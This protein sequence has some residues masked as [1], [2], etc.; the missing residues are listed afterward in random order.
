[1]STLPLHAA[2]CRGD[3]PFTSTILVDAS[4]VNNSLTMS[5]Q[6]KEKKIII[7]Q[8]KPQ[9]KLEEYRRVRGHRATILPRVWGYD[10]TNSFGEGCAF[11]VYF[12][13]RMQSRFAYTR[14]I[15]I[16]PRCKLLYIHYS[17]ITRQQNCYA[18]TVYL[19]PD[20]SNNVRSSYLCNARASR[21]N[22]FTR[23][24]IF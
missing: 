3:E 23:T 2:K 9:Y 20:C 17:F 11:F 13:R 24:Y 1:M 22:D 4:F 19:K 6:Q 10:T 12:R 16:L 14:L 8:E 5:L 7:R 18:A 15:Y 21:R